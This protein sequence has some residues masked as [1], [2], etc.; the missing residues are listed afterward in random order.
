M[1]RYDFRLER[2]TVLFHFTNFKARA[3][4][5]SRLEGMPS[6]PIAL[7]TSRDSRAFRTSSWE[8]EAL[9]TVMTGSGKVSIGGR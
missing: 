1:R 4:F 2:M 3:Q 8:M 9:S 7:E 6:I 5:L